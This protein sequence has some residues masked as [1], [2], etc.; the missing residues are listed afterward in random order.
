MLIPRRGRHNANILKFYHSSKR[1]WKK[2]HP[3]FV[4]L[5]KT[6]YFCFV[7]ELFDSIATQNAEI[8]TVANS[9]PPLL[10][11]FAKSLFLNQLSL[12]DKNLKYNFH[13]TH[14][15]KKVRA[16]ELLH[17]MLSLGKYYLL[18]F[19]IIRILHK[20]LFYFCCYLMNSVFNYIPCWFIRRL[21]LKIMGA[22]VGDNT[23]INMSQYILNPKNLKIGEGTHINRGCLLDARGGCYIGD[24]VS[25]SYRVSL[26]TGSHDCNSKVF[27]GVYLPIFIDDYVWIGVGAIV[28]QGVKIGKGA[29]IAAGSVV[30]KDIEPYSI[31][32]GVPAKVIGKR[33]PDLDYKCLWKIPFV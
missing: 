32:A 6:S 28:L 20:V 14:Q 7:K 22:S 21:F 9:L 3:N 17:Y 16:G 5:R 31:V 25:I 12:T 33:N 15:Y 13:I 19:K 18:S 8:R 2:I 27:S 23:T 4:F 1:I 29:V 10:K 24:N 11:Y 30:T 26:M